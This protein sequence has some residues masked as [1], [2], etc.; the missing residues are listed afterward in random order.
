MKAPSIVRLS[1]GVPVCRAAGRVVPATLHAHVAPLS[2]VQHATRTQAAAT[3][4]A[5]L[6]ST[7]PEEADPVEEEVPQLTFEDLGVDE[8][9]AVRS[10]VHCNRAGYD[11]AST[12]NGRGNGNCTASYPAIHRAPGSHTLHPCR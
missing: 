3:D 6:D 11:A 5:S 4:L 12:D 10:A 2:N 1:N 8:R 7:G 9:V